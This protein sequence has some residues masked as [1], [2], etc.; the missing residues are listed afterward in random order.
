MADKQPKVTVVTPT[1]VAAYAYHHRPDTKGKF[2]DNKYKGQLVVDGNTDL[3]ALEK[4]LRD[5]A[6]EVFPGKNLADLQLPWKDGKADKEE[7]AGKIIIKAST[8][9]KPTVVDTKRKPLKKG[10]EARSGDVVRY[11]CTLYAYE[12]VEKVREGG[13]L[14]EIT[15]YGVSLQ[16]SAVQLV[17]KRSGG[18]ANLG[19]LDDIDGFDMDDVD[20]DEAGDDA[21]DNEG[22]A[23]DNGGDF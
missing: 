6:A 21:G 19:A 14:V 2:A 12:Q 11:V 7:F 22:G 23:G 20:D 13:K 18:G 16:L 17:E 3:S 8:K 4:T 1:G 9:H 10:V 5:F 15:I